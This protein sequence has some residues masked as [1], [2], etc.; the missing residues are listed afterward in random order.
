MSFK[1]VFNDVIRDSVLGR[2]EPHRFTAC[3][4]DLA[5]SAVNLDW[6]LPIAAEF[7]DEELVRRLSGFGHERRSFLS[8]RLAPHRLPERIITIHEN[9]RRERAAVFR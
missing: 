1:K 8:H 4:T 2:F 7:E 5:L 3:I 6:A 9:R